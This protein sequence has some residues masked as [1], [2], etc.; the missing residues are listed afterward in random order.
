[1]VGS[2]MRSFS[3]SS[4]LRISPWPGRNARIEPDSVR[5]AR[6]NSRARAMFW[7]HYRIEGRARQKIMRLTTSDKVCAMRSAAARAAMRRGFQH[8]D[9]STPEPAFVHQGEWDARRLASAGW[10]DE[11]G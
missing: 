11:D 9:L 6:I 2:L 7:A 3:R 1:M 8:Q 10:G 5:K 4:T